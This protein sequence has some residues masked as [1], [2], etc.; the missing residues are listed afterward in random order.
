MENRVS[1]MRLVADKIWTK[2]N[3]TS[4]KKTVS[5]DCFLSL[6]A[7]LRFICIARANEM[8]ERDRPIV[9]ISVKSHSLTHAHTW[10]TIKS[11]TLLRRITRHT[12]E[13]RKEIQ[14]QLPAARNRIRFRYRIALTRS[15]EKLRFA[16]RVPTSDCNKFYPIPIRS[17]E[18]EMRVLHSIQCE[19]FIP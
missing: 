8:R 18:I 11:E 17:K 9:S 5:I 1:R 14:L 2:L 16:L 3:G 6:V 7:S 15:H 19:L 10:Q 4:R 12:I 13:R